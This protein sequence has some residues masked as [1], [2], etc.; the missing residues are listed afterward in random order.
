MSPDP[1]EPPYLTLAVPAGPLFG[2]VAFVELEGHVYACIPTPSA[3]GELA[4]APFVTVTV[5]AGQAEVPAD[6]DEAERGTLADAPSRRARLVPVGGRWM[7][8]EWLPDEPDP[9]VGLVRAAVRFALSL[10]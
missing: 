3:R 9:A 2:N 7:R 4:D 5:G 8:V 10:R 1:A 6:R